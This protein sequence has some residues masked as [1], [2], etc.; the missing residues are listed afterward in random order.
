MEKEKALDI[1][2]SMAG[3]FLAESLDESELRELRDNMDRKIIDPEILLKNGFRKVEKYEN[4]YVLH[5]SD[6]RRKVRWSVCADFDM[7]NISISSHCTKKSNWY[8]YMFNGTIGYVDELQAMM[9]IFKID[10]EITV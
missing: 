9:M 5:Y 7:C 3:G 10:K 2:K 4:V 8:H 6:L 1:L